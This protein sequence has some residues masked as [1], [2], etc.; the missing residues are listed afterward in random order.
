MKNKELEI[1]KLR[2]EQVSQ[3][4]KE[5]QQQIKVFR[6]ALQFYA[7]QEHIGRDAHHYPFVK[8][9]GEVARMA[10][11]PKREKIML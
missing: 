2:D 7:D 10:L 11:D 8:D 3:M 5:Y 9:C 1:L 4:I 6:E